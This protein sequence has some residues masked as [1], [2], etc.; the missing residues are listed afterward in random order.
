MKCLDRAH[1]GPLLFSLSA[2]LLAGCQGARPAASMTAMVLPVC[3]NEECA[4]LD[5]NGVVQVSV[6]NDYD[7]VYDA[8]MDSTLL[9]ARDGLWNLASG[10]GKQV[11]KAGF[12]NELWPLTPGYFGFKRNGKLGVMDE[13]G[14]EVQPPAYDDVYAGDD[15]EFI[16]Y[17]VDGK[18]GFLSATGQKLSD[19]VFDRSRVRGNFAELGNWITGE[20]EGESWALNITTGEL[21]KVEFAAID[22][23]A[24]QVMVVSNGPGEAK[25]LADAK[26]TL[27]TALKYEWMGKPGV[28]L[29]A[30]KEAGAKA[31]GYMDFTG[32]TVIPATFA[33]CNPF[34]KK[35]AM[36]MASS[37]GGKNK[38]GLIGRDGQWLIE[39]TY[40]SVGDVKLSYM[41]MLG[42][43][44]GYSHVG[45]LQSMF[46]AYYGV[47]DLNKGVELLKPA[48]LQVGVLTENLFAFSDL[49]SP[50]RTAKVFM[51]PDQ[52]RTVGVVD[53]T[54]KVLIK[55]EQFV[56]IKL[57]A[58]GRYLS[59][60]EG[61]GAPARVA[62]YALDG[63]LLVPA[64]WQALEVD[65]ARGAI[66]GY[67]VQGEGDDAVRSLR[68][69][70]RLDG[71]TVFDTTLV[72]AGCEVEQ[73]RNGKGEV[74]WP[75]DPQA[76]CE[77]PDEN[78]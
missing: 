27:V 19:P 59:A 5:Q 4:V 40:D 69:L 2:L 20:R 25:G 63:T 49:A 42:D 17:E 23:G 76:Y 78:T 12:T 56:H 65:V 62:L 10:D 44:P 54:G 75:T 39:P 60:H 11:L 61:I 24:G 71:T 68:A 67:E 1:V 47:F 57:D 3:I 32:K 28:G 22:A 38:G 74:L 15:N 41:G 55:P 53:A 30:F 13:R 9:F 37:A 8:P 14:K 6:D 70:Y 26:G 16:V 58:S 51:Q 50:Y 48:Y 33:E 45:V 73:V 72:K 7:A 21:K 18:R 52:V 34:G 46:L 43:V 64:R 36:V 35:G 31:C 66:F 29:V 77:A